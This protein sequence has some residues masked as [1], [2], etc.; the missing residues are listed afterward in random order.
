MRNIGTLVM[1]KLRLLSRRPFLL[2]VCLIVPAPSSPLALA[3][4]N[5]KDQSNL[6]G[7]YVE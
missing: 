3:T 2:A 5:Q 1:L 6:R 7:A 4:L